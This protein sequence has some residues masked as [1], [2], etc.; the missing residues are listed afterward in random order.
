MKNFYHEK[1]AKSGIVLIEWN[2]IAKNISVCVTSFQVVLA[3]QSGKSHL[4]FMYI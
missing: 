3:V 2:C 4:K 1:K